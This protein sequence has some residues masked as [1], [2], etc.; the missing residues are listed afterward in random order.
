MGCIL[1]H[2]ET[3]IL[4]VAVNTTTILSF[5]E[6]YKF[7]FNEIHMLDVSAFA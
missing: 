5:V 7:L 1:L 4:Y 2:I 3:R 6:D